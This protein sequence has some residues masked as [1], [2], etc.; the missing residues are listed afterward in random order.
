ML[1]PHIFG[2]CLVSFFMRSSSV[3]QSFLVSS[4]LTE[5]INFSTGASLIFVFNS[6][7]EVFFEDTKTK[8]EQ[9]KSSSG[10]RRVIRFLLQSA[11]SFVALHQLSYQ[12]PAEMRHSLLH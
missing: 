1:S 3:R 8:G 7:I 6:A 12:L 2:S 11:Y 10:A 4:S 5:L 9:K